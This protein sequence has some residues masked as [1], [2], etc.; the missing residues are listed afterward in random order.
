MPKKRE[1]S[2]K[3]LKKGSYQT[4]SKFDFH[5][6]R[7]RSPT[8]CVSN[9]LC[10]RGPSMNSPSI[11]RTSRATEDATKRGSAAS[12]ASAS[13]ARKQRPK[14]G[15][16]EDQSLASQERVKSAWRRGRWRSGRSR[17]KVGGAAD[18]RWTKRRRH[19]GDQG[20]S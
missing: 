6:H 13:A 7:L 19:N 11:R 1:T 16:A 12:D 5:R 20:C 2:K 15:S 9:L 14:R 4:N 8:P 10:P 3:D 18:G 17:K